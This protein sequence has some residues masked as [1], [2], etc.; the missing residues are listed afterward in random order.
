MGVRHVMIKD[1]VEVQKD[2]QEF[3][4][5]VMRDLG[6]VIVEEKVSE[7]MCQKQDDKNNTSCHYVIYLKV[8]YFSLIT[9]FPR[10]TVL[11]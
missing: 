11:M 5:V 10:I 3:K 2:I 6:V 1:V 7:V 9:F 8:L 4:Q